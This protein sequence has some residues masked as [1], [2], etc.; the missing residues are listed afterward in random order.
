M[1]HHVV[2]L[3]FERRYVIFFSQFQF[4]QTKNP[5]ESQTGFE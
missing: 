3:T 1:I 2:F 5:L 4:I